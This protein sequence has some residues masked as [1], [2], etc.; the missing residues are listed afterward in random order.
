MLNRILSRTVLIL[1]VGSIVLLICA[2]LA[3]S[4]RP[5]WCAAATFIPAWIWTIIGIM[6]AIPFAFISIRSTG[7]LIMA[8]LLFAGWFVEEAKSLMQR[9]I[10]ADRTID[11]SRS[12]DTLLVVSFNCAGGNMNAAREIV[13]IKPDIVFLQERPNDLQALRKLADEIHGPGSILGYGTDTAVIAKGML[14]SDAISDDTS[15]FLSH[16]QIRLPNGKSVALFSIHLQPPVIDTDLLSLECWRAHL[17]DR[18]SRRKQLRKALS[19]IDRVPAGTPVILGGDFN[20]PAN[21]GSLNVLRKSLRDGFSQGG[22]GIGNTAINTLPL[23]RVDQIWFSKGIQAEFVTAIQS[24][25]S[26]H[27]IVIGY[28]RL[29][30]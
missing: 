20:V 26:D 16:A 24:T 27:R 29:P 5:D 14:I 28:Y 12:K 11:F 7:Y 25:Y 2:T 22:W 3:Y 1:S 9:S 6:C 21:D 10:F 13:A 23:F 19:E 17:I 15:R 30:D 18:E 4:S 8:W